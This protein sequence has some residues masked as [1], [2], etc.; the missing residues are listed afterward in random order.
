MALDL[1]G[2]RVGVAID[3]ELGAMAHPRGVLDGKRKDLLLTAIHALCDEV[4]VRHI[5][6][7]LPL[8][9]RGGEGDAARR[10]RE[11]AHA[12]A[13]RTGRTVELWDER[14]TTVEARRAL[15]ASE[16]GE[17]EAKT[18]IDEASACVLLQAWLDRRA[19]RRRAK[20]DAAPR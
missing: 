16:L 3:D 14:L 11:F 15:E 1:G 13:N 7:G 18:R 4:G 8:D 2:V 19:A 5:V 9:M 12:I 20:R 10:A 17:R 6:V